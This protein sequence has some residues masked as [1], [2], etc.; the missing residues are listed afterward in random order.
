M[1][2]LSTRWRPPAAALDAEAGCRLRPE[3]G[4]D[5]VRAELLQSTGTRSAPA[6]IERQAG[7]PGRKKGRGEPAE[8]VAASEAQAEQKSRGNLRDFWLSI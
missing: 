2:W 3:L 7:Q 1:S 4:V 5:Q 6:A 8:A